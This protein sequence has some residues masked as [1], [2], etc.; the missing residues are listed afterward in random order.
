MK[1]HVLFFCVIGN[2]SED[3]YYI[4]FIIQI[5]CFGYSGCCKKM[6]SS[7]PHKLRSCTIFNVMLF[8]VLFCS[9]RIPFPK[10]C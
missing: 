8:L 1:I 10:R 6:Y 4:I 5:R 9:A 7:F 3:S 2:S